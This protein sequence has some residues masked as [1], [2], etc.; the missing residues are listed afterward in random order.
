VKIASAVDSDGKITLWDY[1]VY[2]AGDRAAEMFYDA[3]DVSTRTYMRRGSEGAKLHPFAIGPWRAPGA[4]TNVF[5]RESQL[6][7]MAAAAG[8]DPL[9]FRLKNTS[10]ERV[11]NTLQAAAK[12]FGWK[13][14]AGPS[15][16]GRGI[17]IGY[18][19]GTYAAIVAQVSVDRSTGVVKVDRVVCSQDMG[20]VVNPDGARMQMEGCIAMGLGYVFSEEIDFNGGEIRSMDFASYEIP[21]F[22]WMPPI[23]TV[24]VSN[25]D[26]APQGG[27]EPAIVPLGAAVANA[28]FDATG[29]RLYRL[30]MTRERVLAAMK[31]G[32]RRQAG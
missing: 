6:D 2:A 16:Q 32:E 10:D 30:P 28:V 20:I 4:G 12:A 1:H 15:G 8:I 9:E 18:D 23:E 3:P 11:R 29:V 26:L 27:G 14:A 19:S 13:S 31:E 21:R 7:I 22:S 17:A 25:D 24:L 5:A